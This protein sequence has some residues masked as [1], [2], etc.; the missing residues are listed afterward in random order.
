MGCAS[1]NLTSP[2]EMREQPNDISEF[3]LSP[4]IAVGRRHCLVRVAKGKDDQYYAARIY[5][6]YYTLKNQDTVTGLLQELKTLSMLQHKSRFIC[7]VI[8]AFQDSHFCYL[9]TELCIGGSL[10]YN[11]KSM[12]RYNEAQAIFIISQLFLALDCCHTMNILHRN[13][14][15][16]SILITSDGYIK[17]SGFNHAIILENVYDECIEDQ[18]RPREWKYLAPEIYVDHSY[19]IHSEWFSVGT[20]LFEMVTFD[21][22]FKTSPKYLNTLQSYPYIS[23]ECK[24]FIIQL[25]NPNPRQRLGAEGGIEEIKNHIWLHNFNW[26]PLQAKTMPSPLPVDTNYFKADM[27]LPEHQN[28]IEKYDAKV[29][30]GET[31]QALFCNYSLNERNYCQ[32]L[33]KFDRVDKV[34]SK[35]SRHHHRHQRNYYTQD[36][37]GGEVDDS[38]GMHWTYAYNLKSSYR[39]YHIAN[40]ASCIGSPTGLSPI[41]L[42]EEEVNAMEESVESE[43]KKHKKLTIDVTRVEDDEYLAKRAAVPAIQRGRNRSQRIRSFTPPMDSL[44]EKSEEDDFNKQMQMQEQHIGETTKTIRPFRDEDST[45]TEAQTQFTEAGSNVSIMETTE[46]NLIKSYTTQIAIDAAEEAFQPSVLPSEEIEEGGAML[47]LSDET[48]MLECVKSM[49]MKYK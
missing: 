8:K 46:Q 49:N 22:S 7:N 26:I 32:T 18:G 41:A 20:I 35:L 40:E 17:L 13:I 23:T 38:D 28:A 12:G 47:R 4:V 30:I 19:G 43:E 15:P 24:C 3:E 1:S 21:D 9:I 16:K 39:P 36:Q 44:S 27:M 25:L 33:E 2:E 31:D 29:D 48:K 37:D 6:K 10:Y 45:T 42:G 11:L 5:S 14:N 34:K